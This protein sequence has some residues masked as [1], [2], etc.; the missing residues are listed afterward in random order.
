[1]TVT[2]Q[3]LQQMKWFTSSDEHIQQLRA[4]IMD[5]WPTENKYLPHQV[6]PYV[7]FRVVIPTDMRQ[8]LIT[9]GYRWM[10][11]PGEVM[12]VPA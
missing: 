3:C 8:P 2:E 7:R 5:V 10:F 12:F 1:M 4:V 6:A 11:T 9:P